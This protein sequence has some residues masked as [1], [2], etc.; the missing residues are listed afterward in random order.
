[1]SINKFRPTRNEGDYNCILF[2][3]VEY[4]SQRTIVSVANV[5]YD[6]IIISWSSLISSQQWGFLIHTMKVKYLYAEI[7][8][9]LSFLKRRTINIK[10]SYRLLGIV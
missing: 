9:K 6:T 10:V 5:N 1:M 7:P 3:Q 4:N 2:C 8:Q